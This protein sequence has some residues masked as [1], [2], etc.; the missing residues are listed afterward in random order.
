MLILKSLCENIEIEN[1]SDSDDSV[2]LDKYLRNFSNYIDIHHAGTAMR[3]LTAFLS[4]QENKEFE[5]TGSERMKQRPIKI[6]V[7]AL[8]SL[9]C[10]IRYKEKVGY[11]PLIIKGKKIRK[12]SSL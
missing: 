5:I 6:L 7:N 2:I 9:G 8:S 10:D 11:P 3:F 12:R 4:I 1:L